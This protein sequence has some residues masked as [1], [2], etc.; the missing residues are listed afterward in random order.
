LGPLSN[1]HRQLVAVL[2]L[3]GVKTLIGSWSGGV[4]RPS[5]NRRAIAR[6]FVAKTVFN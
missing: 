3:I 1:T 2:G 6:T 4:G 5:K